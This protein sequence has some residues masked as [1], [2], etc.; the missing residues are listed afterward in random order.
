VSIIN[1]QLLEARLKFKK[2][3]LNK[4]YFIEFDKYE[5]LIFDTINIMLL[6]NK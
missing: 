6:K 3:L 1:C 2:I 5:E 4:K